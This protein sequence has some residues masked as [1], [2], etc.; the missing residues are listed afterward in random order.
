MR[1]RASCGWRSRV[2]GWPG[3]GDSLNILAF[4]SL[5]RLDGISCNALNFESLC[6]GSALG[7]SA[8][9]IGGG[10]IALPGAVHVGGPYTLGRVLEVDLN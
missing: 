9:Q 4:S 2:G 5:T 1:T 7:S 8:G 3:D 10:S 6:E